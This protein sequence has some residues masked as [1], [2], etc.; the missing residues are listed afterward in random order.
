MRN[1][2]QI[3]STLE[4]TSI[5]ATMAMKTATK[6]IR[7]SQSLQDYQACAFT[8]CRLQARD[9]QFMSEGSVVR[10]AGRIWVNLPYARS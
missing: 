7:Q 2:T 3:R 8:K 1:E 4:Q 10:T 6:L 5:D 9:S